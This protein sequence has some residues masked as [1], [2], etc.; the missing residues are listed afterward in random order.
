[1]TPAWA[2]PSAG[3]V[4]TPPPAWGASTPISGATWPGSVPDTSSGSVD[5]QTMS[6]PSTSPV[7]T[8]GRFSVVCS[9]SS[10]A[11]RSADGE[12]TDSVFGA[13]SSAP[14]ACIPSVPTGSTSR[15]TSAVRTARARRG[16]S[17]SR[18]VM[19]VSTSSSSDSNCRSGPHGDDHRRAARGL[20]RSP[21]AGGL[22]RGRDLLV[23]D[24]GG[25]V[26]ALDLGAAGR[27]RLGHGGSGAEGEVRP[28][29]VRGDHGGGHRFVAGIGQRGREDG[30]AGDAS[31]GGLH[32][33]R[34]RLG[35]LHREL[36][37]LVGHFLGRFHVH[38]RHVLDVEVH[39]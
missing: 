15:Q 5:S 26:V 4:A 10:I 18:V 34:G 38:H 35:H 33:E 12:E 19:V 28:L 9:A 30:T 22:V 23:V 31:G 14:A 25:H 13:A 36:D 6:D 1:G 21:A 39:A 2:A 7:V 20:P 29:P 16:A 32:L 37:R 3:R 11:S 24:R 17:C 27:E 8:S